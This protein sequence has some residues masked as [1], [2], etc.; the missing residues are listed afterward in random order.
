VRIGPG[1]SLQ[2]RFIHNP[3]H[4][5][6]YSDAPHLPPPPPASMHR[7]CNCRPVRLIRCCSPSMI[8]SRLLLSAHLTSA[9][10]PPLPHRLSTASSLIVPPRLPPR[11]TSPELRHRRPPPPPSISST[12]ADH[13]LLPLSTPPHGPATLTIPQGHLR[14]H[15]LHP[16]SMPLPD[17]QAGALRYSSGLLP[18]VSLRPRTLPWTAHIR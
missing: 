2:Y 18:V 8:R 14:H 9:P 3:D 4:A 13:H 10:S 11:V 5:S 6:C 1:P 16:S 7:A 17:L 15:D 12:R